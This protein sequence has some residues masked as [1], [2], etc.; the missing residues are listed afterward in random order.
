MIKTLKSSHTFL[1]LHI[2]GKISAT[3]ITET[4]DN[5]LQADLDMK[6]EFMEEILTSQYGVK[7]PQWQL[8]KAKLIAKE[9]KEETFVKI[10]LYDRNNENIKPIFKKIFVC[11]HALKMRFLKGCRC[12]PRFLYKLFVLKILYNIG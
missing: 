3:W 11:F 4:L 1:R 10:E 5:K 8:Y 2:V 12:K 9:K 7:A 6:Y